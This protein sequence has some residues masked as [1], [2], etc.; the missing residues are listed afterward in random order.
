MRCNNT[1]VAVYNPGKQQMNDLI[2]KLGSQITS[3]LIEHL[4]TNF[5]SVCLF[6]SAVRGA[7]RNGSDID[8]LIVLEDAPLSYHKRVKTIIH[9]LEEIRES[10][11]YGKIE[12]LNLDLEPSFLIMTKMEVETHPNIL[13]L[14][15]H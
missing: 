15:L 6:G 2:L 12:N 9:L 8:F 7:L 14:L 10:K 5:I 3:I 11:E 1:Y 4:R 13:T